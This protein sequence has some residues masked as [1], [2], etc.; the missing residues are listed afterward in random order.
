M[1]KREIEYF[2]GRLIGGA[3]GDDLGWLIEF[4]KLRLRKL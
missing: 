1:K 4:M 3:I 2:H